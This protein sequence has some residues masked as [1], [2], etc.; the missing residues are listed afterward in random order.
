MFSVKI[1]RE[2][3]GQLKI[4]SIRVLRL[5]DQKLIKLLAILEIIFLKKYFSWLSPDWTIGS[6]EQLL[7]CRRRSGAGSGQSLNREYSQGEVSLYSW[8]PVW[9]VWIQLLAYIEL[10]V[11][12]LVYSN[13]YQL[14]RRSAVQGYFLLEGKLVLSGVFEDNGLALTIIRQNQA[15]M[16]LLPHTTTKRLGRSYSKTK[17]YFIVKAVKLFVEWAVNTGFLILDSPRNLHKISGPFPRS[18]FWSTIAWLG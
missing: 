1:D 14:S 7:T 2:P 18:S 10:T 6:V 15:I 13:P 8:P 5:I 4:R 17:T 9:L 12:L 11:D 3:F 16:G